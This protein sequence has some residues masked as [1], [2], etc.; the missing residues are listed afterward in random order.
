MRFGHLPPSLLPQPRSEHLQL[1]VCSHYD[2]LSPHGPKPPKPEAKMKT[3]ATMM[4]NKAC[5]LFCCFPQAFCHHDAKPTHTPKCRGVPRGRSRKNPPLFVS[6]TL[7]ILTPRKPMWNKI[8][9][10]LSVV[11]KTCLIFSKF[12]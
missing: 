5:L 4:Q 9:H 11:S 1:T 7:M 12:Y 10:H 8:R 2:A 3:S 6:L